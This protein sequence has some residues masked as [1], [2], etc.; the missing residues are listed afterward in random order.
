MLKLIEI[1]F[2]SPG[3]IFMTRIMILLQGSD[4]ARTSHQGSEYAWASRSVCHPTIQTGKYNIWRS[5]T[6]HNRY[7]DGVKIAYFRTCALKKKGT[8]F[9]ESWIS[10]W[11]LF[12]FLF[13]SQHYLH[14]TCSTQR[15]WI[16]FGSNKI[17]AQFDQFIQCFECDEALML[18]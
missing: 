11:S 17:W 3:K 16:Y 12:I 18:I 5:Q 4:H 13:V 8:N 7:Q 10:G 14:S 1:S 15:L 6:Q 9:D 2:C